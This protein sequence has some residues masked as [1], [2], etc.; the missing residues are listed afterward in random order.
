[1]DVATIL[2]GTLS[3]L[4]TNEEVLQCWEATLAA[5][6]PG[7]VLVIELLHPNDVFDG[8]FA[9]GDFWE[10]DYEGGK[11]I[12][13]FGTDDDQYDSRSQVLSFPTSCHE[14]EHQMWF[15]STTGRAEAG[16]MADASVTNDRRAEGQTLG[17]ATNEARL[18][19]NGA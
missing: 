3:H 6:K 2:L 13:E 4:Q 8:T 1:M 16:V 5:L 11:V 7:G 10:A 14:R 17:A 9:Q 18:S 12:V 19:L 15:G